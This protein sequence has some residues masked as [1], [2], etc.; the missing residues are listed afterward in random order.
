MLDERLA[1]VRERVSAAGFE[2][3]IAVGH[4]RVVLGILR[5]KHLDGDGEQTIEEAMSPGPSTFRPNV[6]AV[7]LAGL[8]ADHNL[9]DLP[10][11]TND[12]R[13][14]GL[15]LREEAERVPSEEHQHE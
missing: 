9:P 14:V 3:C 13:L 4:D 2:T 15:L 10:I 11:T 5:S 1:D 8:M 12:G 7:Q 6:S